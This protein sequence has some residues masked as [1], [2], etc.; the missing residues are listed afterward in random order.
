[1][2]HQ[3][4]PPREVE[5]RGSR[6]RQSKIGFSTAGQ[7]GRVA[8]TPPA[9]ACD[10]TALTPSPMP[11]FARRLSRLEKR[12]HFPPASRKQRP[13]TFSFLEW[14]EVILRLAGRIPEQG[15]RPA[16]AF[17]RMGQSATGA[18]G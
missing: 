14:F 4:D 5:R 15:F 13:R 2:P 16:S 18:N 9:Q 6:R 12:A 10:R 8:S 3:L 1:V 17:L 7:R 11:S